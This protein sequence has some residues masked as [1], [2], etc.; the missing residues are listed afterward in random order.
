[1]TR[2]HSTCSTLAL[3]SA[4]PSPRPQ[5]SPRLQCGREKLAEFQ[6]WS[7]DAGLSPSKDP[8]RRDSGD[9]AA[10]REDTLDYMLD[11]DMVPCVDT[12]CEGQS[13]REEA[14]TYEDD[15]CYIYKV[16]NKVDGMFYSLK[17][18]K[19]C[20]NE[21]LLEEVHAM[22]A[23]ADFNSIGYKH[24]WVSG[25]TLYIQ[26]EICYSYYDIP[27][28]VH[29]D[30]TELG[31]G[32]Y[33]TLRALH[34][35]NYIHTNVTPYAV[36]ASDKTSAGIIYKLGMYHDVRNVK[37]WMAEDK[38]R[39]FEID[40]LQLGVTLLQM[41]VGEECFPFEK[42]AYD[43]LEAKGGLES[44][45]SEIQFMFDTQ[46]LRD[47]LHDAFIDLTNDLIFP[48]TDD[49]D[50]PPPPP[51]SSGD[52]LN[53]LRQAIEAAKH[54]LITSQIPSSPSSPLRFYRASTVPRMATIP[55]FSS[56]HSIEMP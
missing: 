31:R 29:E 44:A 56:M 55:Q 7:A 42:Y 49:L 51:S 35:N 6:Y 22:H 4:A 19:K 52:Y 41:V 54:D 21:L 37:G 9:L 50:T 46:A 3:P 14:I 15:E 39:G 38:Q 24:C 28:T 36:V 27:H 26:T 1:M 43:V 48:H 47:G 25:E 18:L 16:K 10:H 11:T 33:K 12:V 13:S 53:L 34:A 5:P 40:M 17:E 20:Y 45:R 8:S 23:V 2:H 32:I 30:V